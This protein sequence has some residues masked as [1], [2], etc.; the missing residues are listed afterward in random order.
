MSLSVEKEY[1]L[2]IE[3][4][5]NI[6]SELSNLPLGYV[7]KKNIKGNEQYYLQRREG[8]KIVG[9]YIRSD[10]VNSIFEKI[11]RRKALTEELP[12]IDTRLKE[13]EKAAKL[14]DK[15]LFCHL[16]VYKLSLKMDTLNNYEKEKC[17]SFGDAM[18]AIEGVAVSEETA[19]EINAWKKGD[20]PFLSVFED[21]LKRYGFPVEAR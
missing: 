10:E 21:T 16:M 11:E 12:Q 7:S 20:M 18:N 14:I 6:E 4:K 2:L 3:K 8:R 17:A 19:A 15:N 13:L 1:R 5:H 9:S